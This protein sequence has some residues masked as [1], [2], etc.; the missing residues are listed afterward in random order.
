[1]PPPPSLAPTAAQQEAALQHQKLLESLDLTRQPRP[2]RNPHWKP[3]SR[4]NKNLKQILS[5]GK[6]NR[7]DSAAVRARKAQLQAQQQAQLQAQLARLQEASGDST[8]TPQ[9]QV[10]YMNIE[11][12]PSLRA[13]GHKSYCDITGLPARYTDPK[14]RLRYHDKE[15][16]AVVRSL[17]QASADAYLEARRAGVVLK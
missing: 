1:M 17:P 15:I 3:N 5:E 4:R 14:T 9:Q 16:F 13:M 12:A 10:T 11:S 6:G 7:K 2:F 8:P